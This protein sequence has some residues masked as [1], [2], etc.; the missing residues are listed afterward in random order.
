MPSQAEKARSFAALH[1]GPSGFVLPNPW[2][3]GSARIMANAEFRALAT[4]SAGFANT[5]GRADY[6]VTRDEALEHC[7]VIAA[8]TDLPVTA[9]LE[10]GFADKPDRVADTVLMAS[11]T[12]IVGCSIEDAT[13]DPH[14]PLYPFDLA[15]ERVRLAVVAARRLGFPFLITARAEGLLHGEKDMGEITRR[16]E[17]FAK[18][19]APVVYA[20]GIRDM[21]QARH[22]AN[23]VRVPVNV[24][25]MPGLDTAGLFAA[26]VKR[27]SLGPWFARAAVKGLLDAMAEVRTHGTFDFIRGCPNGAAMTK[28]LEI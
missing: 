7:R 10:N 28:M 9:D 11:E 14:A 2:D 13:G 3:A 8:A 21:D 6:K 20:T 15:V 23:A 25:A 24:M 12:G 19:G 17:A 18:V 4:S 22:V 16:L 5:L 1:E 26:G 27:V